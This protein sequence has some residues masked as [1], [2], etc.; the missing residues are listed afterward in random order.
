MTFISS[1]LKN[2]LSLSLPAELIG[3]AVLAAYLLVIVFFCYRLWKNENRSIERQ[4]KYIIIFLAVMVPLTSLFLGFKIDG[5]DTFLNNSG[6]SPQSL[7]TIMILSA[8]P[9]VLAGGTV[10]PVAAVILAALA[11]LC[12]GLWETHTLLTAFEFAILALIY[13]WM[14]RQHYRTWMYRMMRH[15]A[16]AAILTALIYIPLFLIG[17]TLTTQG[18]L[19]ARL[20]LAIHSFGIMSISIMGRL[21]IAGLIAEIIYSYL[22]FYWVEPGLLQPS[23]SE[24]HLEVRFLFGMGPVLL[25][26]VIGMLIGDWLVAENTANRM[27]MERLDESTRNASTLIPAFMDTGQTVLS[28]VVSSNDLMNLDENSLQDALTH[29]VTHFGFFNQMLLV[30]A[31]GSLAGANPAV[32]SNA[33]ALGPEEIAAV[34]QVVNG[35]NNLVIRVAAFGNSAAS[36]VSFVKPVKDGDGN[37]TG[38]ILGRTDFAT[39]PEA[40]SIIDALVNS[41]G[42]AGASYLLDSNGAVIFQSGG[43]TVLDRYSGSLPSKT[44]LFSEVNSDGSQNKVYFHPLSSPEW[45]ILVSTPSAE[46]Q[47][48]T[49]NIA[50]PLF[51]MILLMAAIGYASIRLGLRSITGNMHTLTEET[52]HI[53]QGQLEHRLPYQGIDE[54]GQLNQAFEQMRQTLKSQWDELNTLMSV[55]Q[56]VSSSLSMDDTIKP[57]LDA[58]VNSGASAARIVLTPDAMLDPLNEIPSRFGDGYAK[59]FYSYLD[60]Q[61]QALCRTRDSLN[62]GNLVRGRVLKLSPDLPHPGS[63]YAV[64]LRQEA[65]YNGVIWVAYD[66]PK[67]FSEAEIRFITNLAGEAALAVTNSRL[68]AAVELVR[69]RLDAILSATPDPILVID[70]RGRLLITNPPALELLNNEDMFILGQPIDEIVH[71]RELLDFLESDEK[72]REIVFPDDQVF[73]VTAADM[74]SDHQMVGKVCILRN[75]TRF[76][77]L[78]TLKTEFVETVSHDLRGP[79]TLMRGYAT[80]MQMVGDLNEQQK[81]YVKKMIS[82]IEGMSRLVNNLLD[83]GRIEAGEG[84]QLESVKVRELIDKV[85]NSLQ[86]QATQ[87]NIKVVTDLPEEFNPI[88]NADQALLHQALYNLVDNGI[89]YTPVGGQVTIRVSEQPGNMIFQVEDTGIGIA[90]LDQPRLFEKF[91]RPGIREGYHQHGSSLGLAIVKSIAD[92]HNGKVWVESQLGKGSRFYLSI[93]FET[94]TEGKKESKAE[95]SPSNGRPAEGGPSDDSHLDEE[96][97]SEYNSIKG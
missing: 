89:K 45:S 43:K 75:I 16:F 23:P 73:S 60:D 51:L 14:I 59:D 7:S 32:E 34:Q 46:T 42:T 65:R 37:V 27:L 12:T 25:V 58:L 81:S 66:L 70:R 40:K 52:E 78:E 94:S 15:P 38:V 86:L 57:I 68:Y 41:K 39:N 33:T 2:H 92:R 36:F 84:L 49:W 64:P 62:L 91:Y 31:D 6:N 48:T 44:K 76:K 55:S 97:E 71:Q 26:L 17:T 93:P 88:A 79:L 87:K 74:V 90:P 69:Q 5:G 72:A 8:L 63:I 11:G 13:C 28:Q 54:I 18:D 10:H 61:I 29:G 47:Q 30:R 22:P 20:D 85:V 80:M 82:G 4:E 9:W 56:N 1:L 21:L 95:A 53:T 3:W 19:A 24:K 77:E 96:G 83:L 50:S 67:V 35:A